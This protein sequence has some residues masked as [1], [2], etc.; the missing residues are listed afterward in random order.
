MGYI[1]L[2]S[3][4]QYKSVL[5]RGLCD[6]LGENDL[7]LKNN[8]WQDGTKTVFCQATVPSGWALDS[9]ANDRWL[10]VT[11]GLGG[12][13][14]GSL[15]AS[16]Q[17]VGIHNHTATAQPAHTHKVLDHWHELKQDTSQRLEALGDNYVVG[18]GNTLLALSNPGGTPIHPTD[19][20]TAATTSDDSP[21]A[22]AHNHTISFAGLNYNLAY[23]DTIIGTRQPSVGYTDMTNYFTFNQKIDFEPWQNALR[24]NDDF[25]NARIAYGAKHFVANSGA[26][27]GWQKDNGLAAGPGLRTWGVGLGTGG[28]TPF[29]TLL[30]FTHVHG[31]TAESIHAHKIPKHSH[32]LGVGPNARPGYGDYGANINLFGFGGLWLSVGDGQNYVQGALKGRTW[33]GGDSLNMASAG[34]HSHTSD[35]N[36]L[37]NFKL[38]YLDVIAVTKVNT[39]APYP[40][41]ALNGRV[42]FKKLVSKQR[43]TEFAK[44][45][46]YLRFHGV[47]VGLRTFFRNLTAPIFW[48][49]DP[50]TNDTFLRVGS[51]G[52]V[53]GGDSGHGPAQTIDLAHTH[54]LSSSTHSH[55]VPQHQHEME[56]EGQQNQGVQKYYNFNQVFIGFRDS[57]FNP[58]SMSEGYLTGGVGTLKG[59]LWYYTEPQQ[60]NVASDSHT[61][62]HAVTTNGNVYNFAYCDVILCQKD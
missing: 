54:T 8:I 59:R 3:A 61:H 11:N 40:W 18:N 32:D 34:A 33:M 42:A 26:L 60:P 62:T 35:T 10:R 7:H 22:A 9:Y 44:Q 4:F 46:E 13:T 38:Y 53:L 30:Q 56:S 29:G 55:V 31:Y 50:V 49:Q 57:G 51:T 58:R 25:L 28:S 39:G 1:S 5:F 2:T 36:P 17:I 14:G 20:R 45:D 48:T 24:L 37:S 43:L 12:G 27:P 23:F 16:A 15:L 47:N 6:A 41:Q 21:S 19:Y 52:G